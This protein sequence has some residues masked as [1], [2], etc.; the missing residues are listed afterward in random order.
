MPANGVVEHFNVVEDI[1]SR[2]VTG[3]IDPPVDAFALEELEEALYTALSWQL[4][5]RLMLLTMLCSRSG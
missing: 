4:P 3:C 2:I 5:R 1:S